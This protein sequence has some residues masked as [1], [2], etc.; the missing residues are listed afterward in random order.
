MPRITYIGVHDAVEI[1]AAGLTVKRGESV[2]VDAVLGK[3]L[4]SQSL[5]WA[6]EKKSTNKSEGA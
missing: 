4:L 1:P 2:E 5:N 6:T 3:S